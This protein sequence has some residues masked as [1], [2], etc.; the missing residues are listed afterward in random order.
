VSWNFE[1]CGELLKTGEAGLTASL[2]ASP[3]CSSHCRGTHVSH[4]RGHHLR[5]RSRAQSHA[6]VFPTLHL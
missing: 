3:N 5:L 6:L 2:S 1:L 4:N